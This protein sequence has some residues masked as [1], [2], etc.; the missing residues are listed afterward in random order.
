VEREWVWVR[1]WGWVESLGLGI[2][3]LG[4]GGEMG[5]RIDSTQMSDCDKGIE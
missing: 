2:G 4:H 3:A 5:V 1:E